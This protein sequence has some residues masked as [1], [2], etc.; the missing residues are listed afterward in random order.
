MD[1][2]LIIILSV[3]LQHFL[4]CK[5]F[6]EQSDELFG[7]ALIGERGKSTDIGKQ[8]AKIFDNNNNKVSYF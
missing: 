3:L 2:K 4:P 1:S 8:N 7:S 5:K 6:V